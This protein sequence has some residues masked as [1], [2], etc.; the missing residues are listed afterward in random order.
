VILQRVGAF[1]GQAAWQYDE[2]S[3][4]AKRSAAHGSAA[5]SYSHPVK[6]KPIVFAQLPNLY[7]YKNGTSTPE[8]NSCPERQMRHPLFYLRFSFPCSNMLSVT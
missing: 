5:V 2:N 8:R 6:P 7:R 1:G 3:R 4:S